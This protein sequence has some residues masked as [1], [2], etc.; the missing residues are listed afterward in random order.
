MITQ[1][2]LDELIASTP[3]DEPLF[4]SLDAMCAAVG[5]DDETKVR[6]RRDMEW[7]WQT[8]RPQ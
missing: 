1:R 2:E 3:A 5:F 6:I 8:R 4:D 7:T